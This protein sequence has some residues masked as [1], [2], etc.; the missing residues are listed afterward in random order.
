MQKQGEL[1]SSKETWEF[2]NNAINF[3][4]L[5]FGKKL[6]VHLHWHGNRPRFL[7]RAYS[8]D[9]ALLHYYDYFINV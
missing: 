2:K 5:L 1:D 7:E 9:E 8:A 3:W 4:K 6:E